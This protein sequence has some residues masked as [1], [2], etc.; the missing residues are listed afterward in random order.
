MDYSNPSSLEFFGDIQTSNDLISG[1]NGFENMIKNEYEHYTQF[2]GLCVGSSGNQN[3]SNSQKDILIWNWIW[4]IS[5]HCIQEMMKSQKVK[6]PDGTRHVMDPIIVPKI[7]TAAKCA[8]SVCE[9]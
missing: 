7:A 2:C 6:E 1:K 8:V 5:M 3:M 9:S 4:V